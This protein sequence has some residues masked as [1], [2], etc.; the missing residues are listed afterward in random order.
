MKRSHPWCSTGS[1]SRTLKTVTTALVAMAVFLSVTLAIPASGLGT[2]DPARVV[3]IQSAVLAR[4]LIPGGASRLVVTARILPGWHINSDHPLGDYYIPTRLTVAA[5][6]D[7]VAGPVAYPPA[8]NVTL[9]FTAGEQLSVFTGTV[10]FEVQLTAAASLRPGIGEPATVQLAYQACNDDQCLRPTSIGY[11]TDLAAAGFAD[12]TAAS[13]PADEDETGSRWSVA[14]VFASY[15]NVLGFLVVLLGGLALNLTPCVY[16]L[17]G[18]TIAFFGNEGGGPRRVVVLAVLYVA[19]IALTFSGVGVAAALSGGLFGG[20]LQDPW[21]LVVIATMLLALAASSFGLFALQPPQWLMQRAGIARRG[22]AGAIAMGL[23]MGVVAAP[24]I[25]P[26][27]LGLLIMVQHSG[28]ALFGF[29]LFFTL[30]VGLGLPY[31]GLALAAGSIRRLPRSGEWLAW[32]EQLFGFILV[33]LAL[34]FLDPIVPN[35]L[36]TRMLPFYA[37]AVGICLGFVSREG[38]NWQPFFVIKSTIG[39]IAVVAVIYLVISAGKIRS[40]VIFQPFDAATLAAATAR[41]EPVV[42][43]FSADWCVPCREME[44]TTFVDPRVMSELSGFVLMRANL[45]AEN[46]H[47]QAIIRQFNVQGVP[48][49]VFIDAA[50]KIRKRRIGYVGPAEFLRY[51]REYERSA[52]LEH[53]SIGKPARP[54]HRTED[55]IPKRIFG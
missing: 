42:L 32:I 34:Y 21:V 17:I 40:E 8:R 31:I 43:D 33:G 24:C 55:E 54:P 15:G 49:T 22:Y 25:G 11:K 2:T 38:S 41:G 44:R 23:G 14:N 39:V 4:P 53:T 7:V 46:A 5:P 10:K 3:S 37:A 1:R 30:A 28:S 26:I 16:P 9:K 48:T 35:R 47:N 12:S 27:V 19:G 6:P 20:A 52:S 50:G 29:A 51:L 13:T 45:T 36:I 18:V